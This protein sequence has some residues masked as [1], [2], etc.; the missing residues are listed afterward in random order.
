[1]A[2]EQIPLIEVTPLPVT[3][4]P[5]QQDM[6]IVFAC[7]RYGWSC[8]RLTSADEHATLASAERQARDLPRDWL[9]TCVVHVRLGAE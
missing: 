8:R 1:V 9:H 5:P 6:Y 4:R 7:G 2:A 3:R